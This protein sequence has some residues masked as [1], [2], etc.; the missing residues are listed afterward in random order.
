MSNVPSGYARLEQSKL[1]LVPNSQLIGPA[2]TSEVISVSVRVRRHPDAPPLPDMSDL[3]STPLSSRRYMSRE[4][5]E[6]LYGAGLDDL[7]KVTDFATAAGLTVAETSAARRTVVLSGTVGQMD[8]AFGVKLG[9][10]KTADQ[11]YRGREGFI[12]VPVELANIVEGVF[13]L[14]NRRMVQPVI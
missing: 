7:K 1:E 10:Y 3:A 11:E 12:Y 6:N 14:D 5:F 2:D 13:G 8:A 9:R 4:E